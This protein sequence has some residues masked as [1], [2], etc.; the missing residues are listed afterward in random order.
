MAVFRA[1]YV[2]FIQF[3]DLIVGVELAVLRRDRVY[4]I[5]SL[6]CPDLIKNDEIARILVQKR[7]VLR[8]VELEVSTLRVG[9]LDEQ[10]VDRL[11][12]LE[13]GPCA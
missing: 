12:L 2:I 5:M 9:L 10:M 8:T 7:V 4:I 11:R 3:A 6:K 13:R 1:P